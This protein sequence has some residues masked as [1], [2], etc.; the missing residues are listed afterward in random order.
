[1][2]WIALCLL[3]GGDP[4]A[5]Q[6]KKTLEDYRPLMEG[7]LFGPP[8]PKS[9]KSE[10][11]VTPKPETPKRK[12]VFVTAVVFNGRENVSQVVFEDREKARTIFLKTGESFEAYTVQNVS[13]ER[14]VLV[15]DGK[16]VEVAIGG[17]LPEE[18]APVDDEALRKGREKL[19]ERFRKKAPEGE[20]EE[21]SPV[22]KRK[23]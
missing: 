13:M 10:P 18:Q 17:R 22:R 21:E 7:I 19:R 8:R 1:M 20:A 14:V 6:E 5:P 12:P 3:L 9:V 2:S 11:A 4:A 16:P 23:K 15:R